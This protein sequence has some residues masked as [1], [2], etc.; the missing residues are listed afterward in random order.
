VDPS[1]EALGTIL[2]IVIGGLLAFGLAR[3]IVSG[4]KPRQW[5]FFFSYKS[6]NA[7]EVRRIAER[8]MA[9]GYRVW[10]AEYEVLL[11]NYDAF[12]RLIGRGTA[13]ST[14]AVLFTT[15][16]FAASKHCS[17]EVQQLKATLAGDPG[18]LIEVSLE[19]PNDARRALDLPRDSPRLVVPLA[20]RGTAGRRDDN[21]LLAELARLTGLPVADGEALPDAR[22]GHGLF[23]ARCAP[24]QFDA[25]GFELESWTAHPADGTDVVSFVWRSSPARL[26]FNVYFHAAPQR[27]PTLSFT[28]GRD[29]LD[30]RTLYRELRAYASWWLG[31]MRWRGIFLRERGLHL[32]WLGGRTQIALSHSIFWARMRKYSIIV[33]D[34]DPPVQVIFTFGVT[35]PP[36]AFWRL[37]PAMDRVVESTAVVR[38]A[39]RVS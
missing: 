16:T 36:E 34:L 26:S 17:D 25:T 27:A 3:A 28:V 37:T 2:L 19:E 39:T 30:D 6:E 24:I 21:R 11:K 4:L 22:G 35:G 20:P 18:R 38:P 31:R 32:V 23:Q 8:L 1:V 10:F 33:S 12:K 15:R 13:R 5:D 7:N 29:P 14:R 9:A